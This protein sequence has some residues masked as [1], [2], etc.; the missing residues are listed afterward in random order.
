V[1]LSS[2]ID[3]ALLDRYVA[4]QCTAAERL[5]VEAWIGDDPDRT[6]RVASLEAARAAFREAA[7]AFDS[8]AAIASLKERINA[9]PMARPLFVHTSEAARP[10]WTRRIVAVGV[11][12]GAV[13]AAIVVAVVMRSALTP[14]S[15][16]RVYATSVGERE[17][18]TLTDGTQVMLAPASRVRVAP[19]FGVGRREVYLD[20]EAYFVVTHDAAHPFAVHAGRAVARDIG[21]RFAVR[22]Y[23]NEREVGVAVAEGAVG[24]GPIVVGRG[25]F[26]SVDAHGAA[27]IVP[28]VDVG[29]A[30]AWTKGELVFT[31]VPLRD[32]LAEVARWYDVDVRLT[33]PALG[34][35]RVTASFANEPVDDI[36]AALAAGFGAR[37]TRTGRVV[38]FTP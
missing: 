5:R 18:V 34:N 35:R 7:P 3:D 25:A 31:G 27:A 22:A 4:G 16:W 19:A 10:R 29:R 1:D 8:R 23:G 12:V 36:L 11:G 32:V 20:G 33:D 13:A 21:T 15:A 9:R 17:N 2:P 6:A 37:E 24:L 30:L 28:G 26:A 14:A 38:E